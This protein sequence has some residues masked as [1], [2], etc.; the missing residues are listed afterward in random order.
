VAKAL[1]SEL[2]LGNV[3]QIITDAATRST[4]AQFGAFFL[5]SPR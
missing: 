2:D 5:Q 4:R 1:A 3:V